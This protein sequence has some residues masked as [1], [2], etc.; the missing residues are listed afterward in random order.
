MVIEK[1]EHQ[2]F[3]SA[4]NRQIEQ[5]KLLSP[6]STDSLPAVKDNWKGKHGGRTAEYWDE[7]QTTEVNKKK[8]KKKINQKPPHLLLPENWRTPSPSG[9]SNGYKPFT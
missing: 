7:G 5:I 3:L 4:S 6:P 9:I 1:T 8:K 2:I